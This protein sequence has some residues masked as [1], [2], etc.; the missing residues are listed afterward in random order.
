LFIHLIWV[1]RTR[2]IAQGTDGVSRRDLGNGVMSGESMLKHVPL[3]EG[4]DTRSLELIS[5]FLELAEGD[6]TLLE[7][8]EWFHKAHITNGHY[9][10]CPV[11]AVADV[12]LEQLC[13][14]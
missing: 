5:W 13:K 12:V 10:W 1:A 11:P 8:V 14:T 2:M 9:L 7:P 4:V 6:W 3:N